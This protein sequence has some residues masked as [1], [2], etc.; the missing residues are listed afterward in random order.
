MDTYNTLK[1]GI[2]NAIRAFNEVL[3]PKGITK[4]GIRLDSGDI[5]YLTKEARKMLDEAGWET[6]EIT[7]SN[8]LDENIIQDLLHQGAQIDAFGVG[9]RLITARSEPVFGGVY[10]LVAVEDENGKIIPKIKLSENVAK[11]TTPQFKKMYRLIDN[12]DGMA[13]GDWMCT[14]DEDIRDNLNGDGSLTIFDPDVTWKTKT[15]KDFTAVPLQQVIYKDGKLVYD[16][17]KLQDIQT[18]CKEQLDIMWDSVKRFDNPHN[19]YVDLS[20]KLWFTKHEL[21]T[22]HKNY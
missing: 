4:C 20:N 22:H 18:Y 5:A 12:A 9:E 14:Y 6:C 19:Y 7:V 13:I 17:P 21:L 10:K 11:I 2:P 1:S 16:L 8:S 15:I 3:K